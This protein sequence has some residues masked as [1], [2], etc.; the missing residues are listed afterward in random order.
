MKFRERLG[1]REEEIQKR[2]D[3]SWQPETLEP[4]LG[5]QNVHFEMGNR[6]RGVNAG[7]IGLV[8]QLTDAIGLRRSIDENLVLFKRHLPYHESDHVLTMAFN[9]LCGGQ[10][11]EDIELLRNNV[12]FLDAMGAQRIPDPTTARD[13]LMRFEES[14]VHDLMEG[15]NQARIRVWKA[16]R[17]DFRRKAVID[18]DGT[19]VETQGEKKEGADFG[20]NGKFGYGPLVVSLANTGDVLYLV[21]RGANRPSHDGAPEWLTR[22]V[23]TVRS[24]GFRSV[25]LRGDTDFALTRHF[26]DWTKDDVSF[27]FGMDANRTFV[28]WAEDLED[29]SWTALERPAKQEHRASTRARRPNLKDV[30][31]HR[32]GFKNLRLAAE[33]YAELEYRP[34]KAHGTYRLVAL[35]KNISVEKGDESLFDEI[36]YFFYVTNVPAEEMTAEEVIFQANARCDQEN[37]IEQLKNGVQ[38]MRMPT[39]GFV[40]NW[41]YMVI[42]ALAWNIK[43]WLALLLPKREGAAQL[44]KMEFRSFLNA[45]ML[46]PA[47]VVRSGRRLVYRFLYYNRWLPL[48]FAGSEKLRYLRL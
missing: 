42:A 13:Y 26:D 43:T 6:V 20:Y 38:A 39:S 29:A 9:V 40:A 16:Q 8:Q 25:L 34:A 27:V 46:V 28:K 44:A 15:I 2:L 22:A 21:N 41:A 7:G 17:S 35:R 14:D 12:S 4:V 3:P 24:G 31:I 30:V 37:I 1:E 23:S 48:V 10:S 45:I 33:S 11:I 19:I 47:Q 5:P 36:R 18:V 32:R